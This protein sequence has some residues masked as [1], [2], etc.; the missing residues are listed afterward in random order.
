MIKVP[1]NKSPKYNT[2]LNPKYNTAIN[3]KY[4]T[5][6]NPQYNRT[7]N[8][9]SNLAFAGYFL[10]SL[11]MDPLEFLVVKDNII[12][13]FNDKLETQKFGVKNIKNGFAL[14]DYQLNNIGHL[15]S[16]LVNG[17]NYFDLESNWIGFLV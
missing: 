3:P 17:Y 6:I 13:F 14:F 2:S 9:N 11:N 7:I 16:N 10:Y 5:A 8:P 12:I 1:L 15:E 4:N